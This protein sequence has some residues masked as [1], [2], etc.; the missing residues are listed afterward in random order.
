MKSKKFK[1]ELSPENT[2]K[3][4]QLFTNHAFGEMEAQK[5]R[6]ATG[7]E[8]VPQGQEAQ[9]VGTGGSGAPPIGMGE[10]VPDRNMGGGDTDTGFN[11]QAAIT[12]K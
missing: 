4:M 3:I 1:E 5:Q 12:G 9:G 11:G 8:T 7:Q 2:K 6:G 10:V